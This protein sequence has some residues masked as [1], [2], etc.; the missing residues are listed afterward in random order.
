M[1]DSYLYHYK[2]KV[3][4]VYDGDTF[5]AEI[6]LGFG[7]SWKGYDGKGVSI[8][9][10]GIDSPELKGDT[11]ELGLLSRDKLR[12]LILDKEIT[13]KTI[14]DSTEKYGRYLGIVI[15]D[16]G[17][18]VNDFMVNEGYAKKIK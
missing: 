2:C 13:V 14:K 11:K 1:I 3:I 15:L 7:L 10:I 4:S 5:R 17:T 9:M 12:E 16:D 18:N 6:N 8:R